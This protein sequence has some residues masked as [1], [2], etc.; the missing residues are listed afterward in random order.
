MPWELSDSLDEYERVAVPRL[1]ADPVRQTVPLSVLASLRKSGPARFGDS[2]PV[3]GWHRRGD[4]TVD[5]ALLQTPPYALMLASGPDTSVPGLLTV[6]S[7]ERGL[8]AAVHLEA[9]REV[10]FLADWASVT[11]GGTGAPRLRSRLYRLGDL[12]PPV[13]AP[14]GSARLADH[15]DT[16]LLVDWH[17]AFRLEAE[18]AGP[19]D[20]RRTVEERLSYRGLVLWEAG[21]EPVAMAGLTHT[22]AGVARVAGVYTPRDHRRQGYGSAVTTAASEVALARGASEVVLFTDLANPTSN[23]IYQALGYRPV[24]DRVLLEL[25]ADVTS[26]PRNTS[27]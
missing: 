19:E 25:T 21:G 27:P 4:G 17:A 1:L 7:A 23:A 16:D 24:E 14:A 10:R 5:G 26:R 20:A 2:P 9:G 8:P 22:V 15:A 12:T 11:G 13:P 6:L 18:G 3:F